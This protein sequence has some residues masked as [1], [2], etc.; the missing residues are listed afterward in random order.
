[1]SSATAET[2]GKT[3]LA[4]R[5]RAWMRSR[6]GVFTSA[7]LCNGLGAVG[8]N[9]RAPIQNAIWDFIRR[10]E[11]TTVR[12]N[13]NQRQKYRYNHTWKPK[14]KGV[15]NRRIFKAMYVSTSFASSD[16][17]RLVGGATRNHIE[18]TVRRLSSQGYVTRTGRRP[19]IGGT[20]AEAVWRIIDR[21]RFRREVME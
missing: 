3:G 12:Y 7:A 11:V 5:M 8:T 1:M 18:K 21:D 4:R 9:E 15:L 2:K 13:S 6:R 19:C 20:G 16:L 17:E 10:G 14:A